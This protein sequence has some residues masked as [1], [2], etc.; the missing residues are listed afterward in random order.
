MNFAKH[1]DM[2]IAISGE[3]GKLYEAV[4]RHDLTGDVFS[5]IHFGDPY[6]DY[7]DDEKVSVWM[8]YDDGCAVL[9][10][11]FTDETLELYFCWGLG[12]DL[13]ANEMN[14]KTKFGLKPN[15]YAYTDA[16]RQYEMDRL[17]R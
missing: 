3:K 10:S 17:N 14:Y 1:I 5:R 16:E 7:D 11:P 15:Y 12:P 9:S 13:L 6:K 4:F 8:R 2:D